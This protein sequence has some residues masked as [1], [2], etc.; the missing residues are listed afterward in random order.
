[1]AYRTEQSLQLPGFLMEIFWHGPP[2]LYFFDG[3][4][5]PSYRRGKD[6]DG[7]INPCKWPILLVACRVSINLP[8]I[9]DGESTLEEIASTREFMAHFHTAQGHCVLLLRS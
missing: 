1:M 9:Q 2:L 4:S 3:Q 7:N 5:A 6:H 8:D